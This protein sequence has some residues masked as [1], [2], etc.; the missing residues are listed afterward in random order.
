MRSR[1][2]VVGQPIHVL[3][4]GKTGGMY[5]RKALDEVQNKTERFHFVLHGHK[6]VPSELRPFEAYAFAIRDPIE[7]FVSAFY[8]RRSNSWKSGEVSAF[9]HFAHATDLAEALSGS[10]S[11]RMKA[12]DAIASIRHIKQRY[13]YWFPG[14][15]TQL[16]A[17]PPIAIFR[18]SRLDEDILSFLKLLGL[19][20]L[21]YE[22]E[23]AYFHSTSTIEKKEISPLARKN[24]RREFAFDLTLYEKLIEEYVAH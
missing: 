20:G 23:E 9:Q 5:V 3:H 21:S 12:Q 13:S 7:R 2:F 15:I 22:V 16:R 10:A 4:I 1:G 6:F 18:T 19:E 8:W 17:H 14:G 11:E 24:L